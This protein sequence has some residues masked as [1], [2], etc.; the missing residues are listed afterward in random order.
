MDKHK[1]RQLEPPR[2]DWEKVRRKGH[3]W[4][5]RRAFPALHS[6]TMDR[7]RNPAQNPDHL[8]HRHC[9]D[10]RR[11]RNRSRLNR[12]RG[13]HG[14][15]LAVH[16]HRP[17]A[18]RS[19]GRPSVHIRVQ[20]RP[21]HRGPRGLCTLCNQRPRHSH[22]PRRLPRRVRGR[23]HRSHRR[24]EH[25]AGPGPGCGA[26]AACRCRVSRSPVALGCAAC[27]QAG[28][29]RK[30]PHLLLFPM[31]RAGAAHLRNLA[32]T[33][34]PKS[35]HDRVSRAHMELQRDAN[36]CI[37]SRKRGNHIGL[38]IGSWKD[39]DHRPRRRPAAPERRRPRSWKFHK[40]QASQS[41]KRISSSNGS[42]NSSNSNGNSA[43]KARRR[44][45]RSGSR[46]RRRSRRERCCRRC[47]WWW[48]WK[49]NTRGR[50]SRQG[51]AAAK[52]GD[53]PQ[54]GPSRPLGD[55]HGDQGGS[56]CAPVHRA[57]QGPHRVSHVCAQGL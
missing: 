6:R 4:H 29:A 38:Q 23:T 26:R 31:H 11:T 7:R 56:W 13:R 12:D 17:R 2:R 36:Q 34:I 28:A 1:G 50:H 21:R 45:G 8:H 33:W 10:H 18:Q 25:S 20:R 51:Q 55:A 52:E 3:L 5:Q 16:L 40:Q 22:P 32:R 47:C 30:R 46:G 27:R 49:A 54:D 42:S 53:G 14:L 57:R 9:P 44:S 37:Q 48:R 43:A 35:L 24:Y 15:W 41:H 39:L 19:R